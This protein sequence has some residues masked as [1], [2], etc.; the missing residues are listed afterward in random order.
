MSRGQVR[1][2]WDGSPTPGRA[3]R[4]AGAEAEGG[5]DQHRDVAVAQN[6]GVVPGTK[7]RPPG[8]APFVLRAREQR[9]YKR[10]EEKQVISGVSYR[11]GSDAQ[12]P[13]WAPGGGAGGGP[14]S[15]ET[16]PARMA[17]PARSG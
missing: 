17:S 6:E 7:D 12:R 11:S 5:C 10:P 15:Q 2:P 3:N 16:T 4:E 8:T 9:A 13:C 1:K 14:A